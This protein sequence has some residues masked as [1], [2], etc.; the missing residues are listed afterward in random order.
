M[1]GLTNPLTAF[2]KPW[3]A[4]SLE[5]L[6]IKISQLGLDGVEL[7]VRPGYQVEPENAA[8]ALPRAAEIFDQANLRIESVASELSPRMLQACAE[9]RVPLL[10]TMIPVDPERGYRAS[11]AAFQKACR[12]LVPVLEATGVRVGV[13]NHCG[14]WVGTACGLRQAL[15]PL[16]ESFVAV[17]D[18]AHCALAGEPAA[19]ALEIVQPRLGMVNLKNAIHVT[20]S[21]N[22]Y[23]ESIWRHHWV[24]GAEGLLSW[25]GVA[26]CLLMGGYTGPVCLTAEYQDDEGNRVAEDAVLPYLQADIEHLRKF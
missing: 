6:A 15:D 19:Q 14:N 24:T 23:G 20:E 16:P 5:E 8:E 4:P 7:A 2:T 13:Q 21:L 9:A 17:L 22:G 3:Q 18:F 26:E 1:S 11:V 12:K 10:R 25:S